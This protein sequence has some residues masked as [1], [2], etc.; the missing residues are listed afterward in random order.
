MYHTLFSL[1]GLAMVGWAL[2]IVLPTWRVTRR[3]AES[4]AFPLFLCLLYFIGI[5][6]VFGEMGPGI[7]VL[8]IVLM[9]PFFRR[10]TIPDHPPLR[11]ALR[12]AA[13]G[14]I[15]PTAAVYAGSVRFPGRTL[16]MSR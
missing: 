4:A 9:I 13:G 1:A 12:Y 5:V 3:I 16:T 14:A 15:D 7:M 11:L 2:L 10:T 8:F 6:A